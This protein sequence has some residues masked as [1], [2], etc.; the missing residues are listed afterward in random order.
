MTISG[1]QLTDYTVTGNTC[2]VPLAA[3]TPCVVTVHFAPSAVGVRN[4]TLTVSGPPSGT[5]TAALTG[6]GT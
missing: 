4:A 6:T 1:A 5:A 3:G 2:T